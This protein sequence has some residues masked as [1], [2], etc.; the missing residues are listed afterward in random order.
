MRHL[1]LHT[2]SIPRT[3]TEAGVGKGTGVVAGAGASAGAVG[4][5]AGLLILH[6]RVHMYPLP[7]CVHS[8]FL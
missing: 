6:I 3:G 7:R 5:D 1:L 4:Q 8:R 2:A